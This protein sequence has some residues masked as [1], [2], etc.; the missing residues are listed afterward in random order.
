MNLRPS[1]QRQQGFTLIEVLIAAVIMF[2]VLATATLSLRGALVASERA[3]RT[4]ELLAPLPWI[5]STIRDRLR[6]RVLESP[7]PEYS[8]DGAL[9]G[10]DYRFRA[11]LV[12]FAPPP[13]R[14]DPDVA[15][16][17]EYPPRFGL[18]D[19]EL[20]LER[21]G[22]ISSFIYQELAWRPLQR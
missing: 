3:T 13:S 15:N 4:T 21:E 16:F 1:R 7:T 14:F 18:Y 10:V 22:E 12:S 9:F 8:G 19:V 20:T 11:E 5:T 6:D 2:T 17:I